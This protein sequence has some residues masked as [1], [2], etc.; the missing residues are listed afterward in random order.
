MISRLPNKYNNSD[1]RGLHCIKSRMCNTYIIQ[2]QHHYTMLPPQLLC[3]YYVCIEFCVHW[4]KGTC[5]ATFGFSMHLISQKRRELEKRETV[6]FYFGVIL[7]LPSVESVLPHRLL[8]G[9]IIMSTQYWL[10][11]ERKFIGQKL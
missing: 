3:R 1:I 11:K 4:Q 5:K 7:I 6:C 8:F 10:K 2:L 9:C